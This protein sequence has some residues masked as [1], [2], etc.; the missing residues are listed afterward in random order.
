MLHIKWII[1]HLLIIISLSGAGFNHYKQTL[2]IDKY[3]YILNMNNTNII[4]KELKKQG[5]PLYEIDAPLI[6]FVYGKPQ[7]GWI[8]I[9]KGS[10]LLDAIKGIGSGIRVKTKKIFFYS[11][12]TIDD[13]SRYFSKLNDTK[14][15]T[16]KKLYHKFSRWNESGIIA[17]VYK[18]P[19]N[20]NADQAI[21]YMVRKSDFKF[22]KIAAKYRVKYPSEEFRRY[23]IIASIIQ[24]ESWI[25]EEM[26]KI[27]AVIHNRLEKG[28]RLQMDATL[29]YGRYSH[30]VVTPKRI[31]RDKSPYNTYIHKGLPPHPLGSVTVEALEAAF[32]PYNENFLYFVHNIFGTH[33][34]SSNYN[35][36][37]AN[38]SRI[39][40]ERAKLRKL[41]NTSHTDYNSSISI[42]PRKESNSSHEYSRSS[43]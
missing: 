4:V 19:Y 38:I 34:F 39:K 29:N 20:L 28:M 12:D 40:T 25:K 13:F 43:P 8:H 6:D 18:L 10:T 2:K 26:P 3:F 21:R 37:L 23:L 14:P 27:S 15:L 11:T 17:A 24:K 5:L 35:E 30:T 31:R 33:D 16:V 36:H 32:N 42:S 41:I 1:T 7:P 9:K 22:K